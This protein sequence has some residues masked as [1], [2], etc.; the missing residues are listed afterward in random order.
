MN[1]WKCLNNTREHII[2]NSRNSILD[3]S[4]W[5]FHRV[6]WTLNM[7]TWHCLDEEREDKSFMGVER[8]LWG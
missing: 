6:S 7:L 8:V 5:G 1:S 4:Q 3:Q 2:L